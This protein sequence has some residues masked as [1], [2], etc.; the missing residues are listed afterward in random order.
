MCFQFLLQELLLIKPQFCICLSKRVYDEIFK[1]YHRNNLLFDYN[2]TWLTISHP[3]Y[4]FR[5]KNP[6]GLVEEL[7][8]I[9]NEVEKIQ[10]DVRIE[11]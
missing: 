7:R 2:I 8:R 3:S 10:R 9:H 4:Y 11:K 1:R 5:L 6:Q